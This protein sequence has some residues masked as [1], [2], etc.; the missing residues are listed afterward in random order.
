MSVYGGFGKRE[1]ENKYNYTLFD[2]VLTLATRVAATLKNRTCEQVK[3]QK[4]ETR[5]LM[6]ITKCHR[7]LK[8]L[9]EFKHLRPFYS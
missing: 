2:L 8:R 7:K 6:H 4:T 9:E 5:F 3:V 1:D